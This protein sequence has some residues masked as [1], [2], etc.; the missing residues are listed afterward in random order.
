MQIPKVTIEDDNYRG[1]K[2]INEVEFDDKKHNLF[3]EKVVRAK[4]KP[5]KPRTTKKA[6]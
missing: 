3:K 2:N 6:D 4:R 5:R 1:F